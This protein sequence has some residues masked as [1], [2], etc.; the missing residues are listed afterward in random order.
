VFRDD[1]GED[2]ISTAIP[3]I[4]WL[5]FEADQDGKRYCLHDGRCYLMD[6]DYAKKLR[7]QTKAIFDRGPGIDLPE[8]QPDTDEAGYNT[9]VARTIGGTLLDRRLVYT[10]SLTGHRLV[11]PGEPRS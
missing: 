5:A 4:R 2:A 7:A 6:Q 3:G 9:L 10:G 1:A 11:G 8:W